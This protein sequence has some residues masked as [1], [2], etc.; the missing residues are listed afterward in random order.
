MSKRRLV[1][2]IF[3]SIIFIIG[4]LVYFFIFT[5]K[6]STF[7]V[8]SLL[9]KYLHTGSITIEQS[10]GNFAG[11]KVL[12][13]LEI[14]NADIL[15]AGSV[16]RIQKIDFSFASLNPEGLSLS[17]HNGRLMVPGSELILFQGNLKNNL[18][19][20]NLYSNSVSIAE[21]SSLF[22]KEKD[23]KK[24]LGTISAIDIFIKGS[25]SQPE[26]Q[27]ECKIERLLSN[28]F[29][30]SGCPVS[31]KTRLKDLSEELKLFGEVY[32]NAG[33]AC[34]PNTAVIKLGES[35]IFFSGS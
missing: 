21:M 7:I 15:P 27:G 24:I 29:S 13:D 3:I 17:I 9:S 8:R 14:T 12:H 34:G 26:I 35:K 2:I 19:D 33:E 31:F 1:L 10:E 23:F 11:S 28:G 5:N 18:L 25:L 32:T 16:L 4:G 20:F 30:L 22:I 6:G